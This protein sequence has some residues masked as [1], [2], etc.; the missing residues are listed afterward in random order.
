[1]KR[2]RSPSPPQFPSPSPSPSPPTSA[3]PSPSP[4]PSS[5]PS[6]NIPTT[7]ELRILTEKYYRPYS[8]NHARNPTPFDAETHAPPHAR[9][10]NSAQLEKVYGEL[11][12]NPEPFLPFDGAGKRWKDGEGDGDGDVEGWDDGDGDSIFVDALSR[13][14][15][16]FKTARRRHWSCSDDEI[17]LM[18]GARFDPYSDDSS[19]LEDYE[20]ITPPEDSQER[21]V[22]AVEDEGLEIYPRYAAVR[23]IE[24]RDSWRDRH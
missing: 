12:G 19:S 18:S 7:E 16:Y 5:S 17:E 3:H 14:E 2:S 8:G 9:R 6:P 15:D 21:V 10:R 1:M 13:D 20:I 4:T 22:P 11:F 23:S 24:G